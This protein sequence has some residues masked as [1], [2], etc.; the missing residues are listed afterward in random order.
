MNPVDLKGVY[1][2]PCMRVTSYIEKMVQSIKQSIKE[3]DVN[4]KHGRT[5]SLALAEHAVKTKH[6][7]CIEEAKVIA[8]ISYFLHRKFREPISIEN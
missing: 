2:I 4:I 6:H 5:K 7:I 3:H 8:K 1:V